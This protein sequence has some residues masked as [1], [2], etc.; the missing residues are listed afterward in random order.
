MNHLDELRRTA[1][2]PDCGVGPKLR[3]NI[4]EMG[5][6][7]GGSAPF[8]P[9]SAAQVREMNHLRQLRRTHGAWPTVA[10]QN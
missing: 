1:E 8:G 6:T 2:G 5:A 10:R 4:G 7:T 3:R 9:G